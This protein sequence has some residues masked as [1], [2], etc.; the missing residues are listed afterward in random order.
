MGEAA[1]DLALREVPVAVVH[2]LEL[3]AVDGDAIAPQYA[4][5]A[6]ELDELRAGPPDGRAIV[7]P[8]I[9]DRLVIR[10]QAAG[11][12]HQLDIAPGLALQSAAGGNLVQVAVDEELEQDRR[13]VARA[14]RPRR[15]RALKSQPGQIQLLDEQIDDPDQMIL[16][17]PV[18]QPF[19]K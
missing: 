12:P 1:G 15:R 8:E 14:P 13:V 17:D 6:A 10:H 2:R 16:A 7:T 19:W 5:P 9:G 18:L 3:A 11:Q 4:D